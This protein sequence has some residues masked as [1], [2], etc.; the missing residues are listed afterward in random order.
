MPLSRTENW[1]ASPAVDGR[2]MNLGRLR[3]AEH[4]R[5]RNQLAEKLRQ[6]RKIEKNGRQRIVGDLRATLVHRRVDH[7]DGALQRAFGLHNS[8]GWSRERNWCEYVSRS[9]SRRS[10]RCV[11]SRI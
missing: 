4:D 1:I 3:P 5:V 9:P 8:S 6:L 11:A 7:Q 10:M 2:N